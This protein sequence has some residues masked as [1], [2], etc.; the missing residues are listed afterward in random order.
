MRCMCRLRP[1]AMAQ[2]GRRHVRLACGVQHAG[3]LHALP[4][5]ACWSAWWSGG[6][7]L[8]CR[9]TVEVGCGLA[10]C[11]FCIRWGCSGLGSRHGA[12]L[13]HIL[14]SWLAA[15]HSCVV[16]AASLPA[17]W[18]VRQPGPAGVLHAGRFGGRCQAAGAASLRWLPCLERWAFLWQQFWRIIHFAAG[19]WPNLFCN[20]CM[21]LAGVYA[22]CLGVVQLE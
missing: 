13:L 12:T 22:P 6:G 16:A 19:R 3:M 4:G 2:Q 7:L 11:F 17:G 8:A 18:R 20:R 5:A 15:A 1:E 14:A 10:V 9:C 21:L